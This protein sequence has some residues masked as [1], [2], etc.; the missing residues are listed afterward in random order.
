MHLK[1]LV[2]ATLLSVSAFAHQPILD[3][4]KLANLARCESTKC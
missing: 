3:K 4:G 1:T 2:I